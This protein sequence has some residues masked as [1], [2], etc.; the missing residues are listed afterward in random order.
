MKQTSSLIGNP[1]FGTRLGKPNGATKNKAHPTE[2]NCIVE[3]GPEH[4]RSNAESK[5][6]AALLGIT[7]AEINSNGINPLL[8]RAP[9]T[10]IRDLTSYRALKVSRNSSVSTINIKK[11]LKILLWYLLCFYPEWAASPLIGL[12][13]IFNYFHLP[14]GYW[15]NLPTNKTTS[16]FPI[17]S[18][19]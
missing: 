15:L 19:S 9:H 5:D 2:L 1:D 13:M 3:T 4:A 17:N 11:T 16:V 10:Q 7:T 8:H 6:R 14:I 18:T 12:Y